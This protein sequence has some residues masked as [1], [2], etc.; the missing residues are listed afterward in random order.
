[1]SHIAIG[2]CLLLVAFSVHL[3]YSSV[4]KYIIPALNGPC[5]GEHCLTLSEFVQFPSS[6]DTNVSLQLL[7]G[8][9]SLD[10]VL[11]IAKKDGYVMIKYEHHAGNV[12]VECNK[13]ASGRFEITETS[14]QWYSFHRL[15]RYITE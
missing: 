7:P 6:N 3:T 8:N 10:T 11:S 14:Y 4:H 1:M 15:W 2:Q 9:H 5:P 12:F 13:N